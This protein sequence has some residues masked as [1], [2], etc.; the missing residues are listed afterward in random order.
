MDIPYIHVIHIHA[1]TFTR[2]YIHD[3]CAYIQ[4]SHIHMDIYAHTEMRYQSH[5]H[6][7]A[8]RQRMARIFSLLRARAHAILSSCRRACALEQ[9]TK[10]TKRNQER[11]V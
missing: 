8:V 5:A 11:N 10:E 1:N 3:V 2:T 4:I 7:S 6:P 9:G